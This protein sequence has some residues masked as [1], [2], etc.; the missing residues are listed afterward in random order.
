MNEW[1][2]GMA[3][4]HGTSLCPS[5]PYV[6]GITDWM[7]VFPQNSY[8]E[9]LSSNVMV[10]GGG[11]GGIWEVIRFR[12]GYEGPGDTAV[13]KQ[14]PCLPGAHKFLEDQISFSF[15]FF[16]PASLGHGLGE[17]CNLFFFFF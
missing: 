12:W 15:Y 14:S 7:L 10:F 8:V 16:A 1:V 6:V 13:N 17:R 5:I 11:I 3:K 2:G 4:L 9:G